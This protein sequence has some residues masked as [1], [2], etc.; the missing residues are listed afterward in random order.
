MFA[1][2]YSQDH[3]CLQDN[4]LKEKG[5]IEFNT[6]HAVFLQWCCD[7][8]VTVH[9][10]LVFLQLLSGIQHC[11]ALLQTSIIFSLTQKI[12]MILLCLPALY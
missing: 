12:V 2:L 3:K 5:V 1:Y 8:K 7:D 11:R 6:M 10:Y 9:D 4:K